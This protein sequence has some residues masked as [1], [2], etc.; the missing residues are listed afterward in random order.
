MVYLLVIKVRAV[1]VSPFISSGSK[2]VLKRFKAMECLRS[3][4]PGTRPR[5]HAVDQHQHFHADPDE[6]HR[7]EGLPAQPHDL[8]VAVA[9]EGGTEPQEQ[10]YEAEHLQEQPQETRVPEEG[11]T[12]AQR[13]TLQWPLPAAEEEHG[14]EGRDQDHVGILGQEEQREGDAGVLHVKARDDLRL[15]FRDIKGGTVGLR[16]PGD[17]VHD[18]QREQP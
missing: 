15:P 13:I 14:G 12:Q 17:E 6:G 1:T 7:N 8:V 9:W 2:K 5:T 10:E 16:Y 4:E 3:V 18:E 11:V